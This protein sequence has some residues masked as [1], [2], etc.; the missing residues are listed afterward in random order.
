M[1]F[2]DSIAVLPGYQRSEIGTALWNEA[3]K[4]AKD[5]Q[6]VG[7]CLLAKKSYA[8]YQWYTDLGLSESGWV[9][10]HKKF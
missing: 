4:Y 8:S 3:V 6:L 7:L 10:M 9:E 1:L 2:I 5:K